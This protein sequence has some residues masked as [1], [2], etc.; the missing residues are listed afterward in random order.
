[1]SLPSSKDEEQGT[2]TNVITCESSAAVKETILQNVCYTELVY[3]RI[4]RK[5]DTQYSNRQIEELILATLKSSEADSYSM[6]GKNYY[7]S[8]PER[9]MRITINSTSFR[10]ITVDKI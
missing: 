6:T 5:L 10:V 9:N 3:G 1:M 7:I 2:R 8:N 4:N